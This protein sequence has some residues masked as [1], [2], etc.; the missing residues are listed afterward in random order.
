MTTAT[1]RGVRRQPGGGYRCEVGEV[2]HRRSCTSR[3]RVGASSGSCTSWE[4]GR[5]WRQ[6]GAPAGGAAC[7]LAPRWLPPRPPPLPTPSSSSSA[8]GCAPLAVSMSSLH[9]CMS[10]RCA[11]QRTVPWCST[12]CGCVRSTR[13]CHTS[14]SGDG[15]AAVVHSEHGSRAVWRAC[16]ACCRSA[17]GATSAALAAPAPGAIAA[18]APGSEAPSPS[19]ASATS[20]AAASSISRPLAANGHDIIASPPM[21]AWVM[22]AQWRLLRRRDRPTGLPGH[23]APHTE[24]GV[25]AT[26][27]AKTAVLRAARISPLLSNAPKQ[28]NAADSMAGAAC[29]RGVPKGVRHAAGAQWYLAAQEVGCIHAP[30]PRADGVHVGDVAGGRVSLHARDHRGVLV[31]VV[32]GRPPR[33]ASR[34][35]L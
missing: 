20:A 2:I 29:C 28:C 8:R 5:L 32:H 27:V 33:R 18:P 9:S 6:W 12:M 17:G 24:A 34:W 25:L 15:H 7:G 16:D 4:G 23:S 14:H 21:R 3:R 35:N 13:R 30:K 11:L 31:V 22:T 26:P 19:M 1:S 10:M